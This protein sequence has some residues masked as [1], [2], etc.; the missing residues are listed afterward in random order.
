MQRTFVEYLLCA[1]PRPR[2]RHKGQ[3]PVPRGADG[4]EEEGRWLKGPHPWSCTDSVCTAP[5]HL[6]VSRSN[7]PLQMSAVDMPL[8]VTGPVAST[9]L[10]PSLR[11]SGPRYLCLGPPTPASRPTHSRFLCLEHASSP[12]PS[13]L[14][15]SHSL[16]VVQTSTPGPLHCTVTCHS[17]LCAVTHR[18]SGEFL[19]AIC[20]FSSR[21]SLTHIRRRGQVWG[22]S[23]SISSFAFLTY[24]RGGG[25]S[26]L[27]GES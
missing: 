7:G 23:R 1:R 9:A 20:S 18:G 25:Y 24:E 14:W 26:E 27:K 10:A 2:W 4:L 8:P 22:L 3:G 16:L 15:L 21:G 11:P 5:A 12:F 19:L 13:T 17:A 6:E